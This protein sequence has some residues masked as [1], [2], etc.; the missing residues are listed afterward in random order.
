MDCNNVNRKNR[1]VLANTLFCIEA[2]DIRIKRNKPEEN[3]DE[4]LLVLRQIQEVTRQLE[5]PEFRYVGPLDESGLNQV[6]AYYQ[7]V[8][9]KLRRYVLER[10]GAAK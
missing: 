10:M 2:L 9:P 7:D 1:T 6:K 4:I 3:L 8:I 5:C